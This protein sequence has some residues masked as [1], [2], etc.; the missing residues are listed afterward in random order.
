MTDIL[1]DNEVVARLP[2][3]LRDELIADE[4][5]PEAID[6][7]TWAHRPAVWISPQRLLLTIRLAALFGSRE[8]LNASLSPTAVT[9]I[10]GVDDAAL[11]RRTL[12]RGYLPSGWRAAER[13]GETDARPALLVIAPDLVSGRLTPA[14]AA[15]FA[16][17]IEGALDAREPVL[18]TLPDHVRLPQDVSAILPPPAALPNIDEDIL[19][20]LL[21]HTHSATG[22]IDE[23]AVRS[24]LPDNKT[25]ARLSRAQLQIALRADTALAVAQRLAKI[26]AQQSAPTASAAPALEAMTGASEALAVARRM[27]ADLQAWRRGEVAWSE[28]TRSLLLYG[29]PGTGKTFLARAMGASAGI[30]VVEASYSGWQAAGHLGDLLREM[31]RSFAEAR[32]VTPSILF[33]DEIDAAGSREASD[34]H[35]S[36]YRRQAISGLLTELD[37]IARQEG[38]IVVGACN[39]IT[40]LDPAILRPGRLD[41]HV[42]VPLPDAEAL[43]G[44]LARHLHPRFDLGALE[45]LARRAVGHSAASVDAAVR[46]A[47]SIARHQGRPLTLDDVAAALRLDE[48]DASVAWRIAVH[49]CGHA[50]VAT[51]LDRSRVIR[52]TLLREGGE[53]VRRHT[54]H[55]SREKDVQD[56]LAVHLGGRAAERLVF[57]EISGGS[58]GGR[59]SDLAA[60]TELALTYH[61]R[62]GLGC[63]GPIW[64][65]V[66]IEPAIQDPK[67]QERLRRQLVAAETRAGRVLTRHRALLMSMASA[68]LQQRRLAGPE[69]ADWLSRVPHE[70]E[71]DAATALTRRADGRVDPPEG[72]GSAP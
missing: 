40:A 4:V 59:Q 67:V 60:A 27:V 35:G 55:A 16:T 41:L 1:R 17:T 53:T 54:P 18:I 26:C 2:P 42:E 12:R 47:R 71:V 7:T 21:R 23:T 14:G 37:T 46:E 19:I 49:E 45:T 69:L 39:H 62:S 63:R 30:S 44:I 51:A 6:T 13:A 32:K 25:L 33:I 66:G 29:P 72:C 70:E 58:G 3:D 31:G 43:A 5:D 22:R 28:L 56:E 9:V 68:L 36:S 65:N 10:S 15:W 8:R 20:A 48:V 24:A 38:V 61:M 11:L 52:M 64:S 57:G 50:I 34:E